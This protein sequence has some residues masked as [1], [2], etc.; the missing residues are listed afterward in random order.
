MN[1]A[2]PRFPLSRLVLVTPAPDSKTTE[3]EQEST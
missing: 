3:H 1:R 2:M